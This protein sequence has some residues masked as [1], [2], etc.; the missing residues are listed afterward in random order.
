MEAKKSKAKGL[1][2]VFLLVVTLYRIPGWYKASQGEGLRI[3]AQIS[4]L[5]IKPPVPLP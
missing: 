4:L 5:L 1:L 2:R 3:L